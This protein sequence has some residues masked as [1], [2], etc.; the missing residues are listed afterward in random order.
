MGKL[1]ALLGKLTGIKGPAVG[2]AL[3][4]FELPGSDGQS[5]SSAAARGRWLVLSWFPKAF[6][7]G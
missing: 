7:P 1:S 2:T 3:P 6:T 5:H 4:A